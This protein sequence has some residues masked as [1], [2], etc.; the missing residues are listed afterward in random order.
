M[1]ELSIGVVAGCVPSGN[2]IF[3]NFMKWFCGKFDK[4]CEKSRIPYCKN[5]SVEQACIHVDLSFS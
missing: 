1:A 2:Q 5:F 3:F 4:I